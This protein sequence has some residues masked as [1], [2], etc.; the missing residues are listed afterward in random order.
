VG[1]SGCGLLFDSVPSATNGDGAIDA[2]TGDRLDAEGEVAWDSDPRD[3]GTTDGRLDGN[4]PA[5]GGFCAARCFWPAGLARCTGRISVEIDAPDRTVL[6]LDMAGLR[7][8]QLVLKAEVCGGAGYWLHVAD[9]PTCN[10]GGGDDGSSSNDAEIVAVDGTLTAEVNDY[11][12]AEGEAAQAW[13]GVVPASGCA[14]VVMVL[15]D[16]RLEFSSSAHPSTVHDTPYLLRIDPA[17]DDEAGE[18]DAVWYLGVHG[19]VGPSSPPRVGSGANY[20]DICLQ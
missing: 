8:G 2:H 15:R 1:A 5:D 20:V 19:V 18:P 17:M 3:G 12:R 7:L 13:A 16:Q 9:S 10:G 6:A 14:I 11:G 4:L